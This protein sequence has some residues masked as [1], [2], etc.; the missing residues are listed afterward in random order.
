M[1][2]VAWA[3]PESLCLINVVVICSDL[4][5][6]WTIPLNHNTQ[7]GI[8][9]P[10]HMMLCGLSGCRVWT[11]SYSP[12]KSRS[13]QRSVLPK[14]AWEISDCHCLSCTWPVSKHRIDVAGFVSAFM[15]K[16]AE[17]SHL[18]C[19]S[20]SCKYSEEEQPKARSR[21]KSWVNSWV[22]EQQL[23]VVFTAGK[24]GFQI[25]RGDCG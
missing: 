9:E 11:T 20:K 17:V 14:A 18:K 10:S 21:E 3:Q 8:F 12:S 6:S 7:F 13:L 15:L 23:W 24:R 5:R 25:E 4:N 2:S 19:E 22:L 1:P 16:K